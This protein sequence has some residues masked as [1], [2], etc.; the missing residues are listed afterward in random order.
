MAI[1]SS[2]Q[3]FSKNK[4]NVL[5]I[6]ITH[7]GDYENTLKNCRKNYKNKNYI[8]VVGGSDKNIIKDDTLFLKVNDLYEG[9]PE[10]VLKAFNFLSKHYESKKITHFC[11]LDSDMKIVK[12]FPEKL[13]SKY[14]YF[15]KV[16]YTEGQRDWG[17]NNFSADSRFKN[18]IYKGKYV[19]WCLGGYGYVVSLEAIGL[20]ASKPVN[21]SYE[22]FEDLLLAKLLN[23]EN[24]FPENF[25]NLNKYIRSPEHK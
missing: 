16:Q 25:D 5:Y 24:I 6:F 1:S 3:M 10:K 4:F 12:N 13:L 18:E 7:K 19:P 23:E 21:Y 17:Q 2:Q 9:L 11:K 14:Q 8:V 22:P 15:G 20:I